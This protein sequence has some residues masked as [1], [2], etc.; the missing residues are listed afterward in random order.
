MCVSVRYLFVSGGRCNPLQ[1][2]VNHMPKMVLYFEIPEDQA[3]NLARIL[4]K[5]C[6]GGSMAGASQFLGVHRGTLL[7]GISRRN[8]GTLVGQ[9]I[10]DSLKQ[11]YP[12]IEEMLVFRCAG[13]SPSPA[14]GAVAVSEA[15]SEALPAEAPAKPATPA[16]AVGEAA[17]EAP[18]T[19]TPAKPATAAVAVSEAAAEALPAEAPARHSTGCPPPQCLPTGV[20]DAGTESST[21]TSIGVQR[22]H[23]GRQ[24]RRGIRG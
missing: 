14:K 1:R 21:R 18:P 20:R 12:Q 3:N 23:S 4:L 9:K 15:A 24:F 16:A 8:F 19:E 2:G 5:K 7:R 10:I 13:A 17:A 22:H 6:G 11:E